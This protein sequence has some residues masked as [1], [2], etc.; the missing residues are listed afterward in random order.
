MIQ[1]TFLKILSTFRSEYVLHWSNG[2][3]CGKHNTNVIKMLTKKMN[4]KN[5]L[6][7]YCNSETHI[8]R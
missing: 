2:K 4:V 8:Y 3:C 5:T 7:Q 1:I 6:L